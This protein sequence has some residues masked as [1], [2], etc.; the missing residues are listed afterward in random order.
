MTSTPTGLYTEQYGR[1]Y[2]LHTFTRKHHVSMMALQWMW[3]RI[4]HGPSPYC[5]QA[6]WHLSTE[7]VDLSGALSSPYPFEMH[8]WL[9]ETSKG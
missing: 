5:N 7:R 3:C 8:R 6:P 2:L 9:P 1:L 4:G